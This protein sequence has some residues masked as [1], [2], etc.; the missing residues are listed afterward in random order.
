MLEYLDWWL[1]GITLGVFTILYRFMVGRPLGVS[2]SW[3]KIAFWKQESAADK[4]ALAITENQAGATT[5]L[6][7]ATMA[8]FGESA[9]ADQPDTMATGEQPAKAKGNVPWTAHLMFLLFMAVGG[10]LWAFFTGNLHISFELSK[11][12]TE[13]SGAGWE[14]AFVLLFGGFLVGMGTQMAGGC[15]SGHGLSGCATFS[16]SS[17]LATSVFFGTAVIVSLTLKALIQ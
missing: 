14:L 6:M 16:W 3:R 9:V 2:G 15:S 7:A 8:E 10:L 4:A 13:I 17:I 11:I 12:H 5:A 1:G